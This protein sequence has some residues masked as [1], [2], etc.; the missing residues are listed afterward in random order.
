MTITARE[1]LALPRLVVIRFDCAVYLVTDA[2]KNSF[3]E[4][5]NYCE[6]VDCSKPI[7][8]ILRLRRD[9][10]RGWVYRQRGARMN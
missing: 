6:D 1:L 10:P 5:G 8:T 2:H 4:T 3:N 9:V 7:E